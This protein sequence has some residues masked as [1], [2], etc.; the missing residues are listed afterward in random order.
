MILLNNSSVRDFYNQRRGFTLIELLVVI[1]ILG[2]LAYVVT[3]DYVG[4]VKKSKV[5]VAGE[6][7]YAEL[8]DLR[9]RVADGNCWGISV[10]ENDIETFYANYIPEVGCDYQ[11]MAVSSG[12]DG[13][14]LPD[15]VTV[16]VGGGVEGEEFF[17]F[18]EPP[19]GDMKLFKQIGTGAYEDLET[20]DISLSGEGSDRIVKLNSLTGSISLENE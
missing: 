20:L 10:S 12:G 6:S 11:A 5:R 9:I 19:Y 8:Q 14:L 4:E 17:V 1:A 18:F 13:I 7:V 16:F 15:G 2:V 3:A